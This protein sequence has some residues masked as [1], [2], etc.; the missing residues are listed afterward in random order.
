VSNSAWCIDCS[1]STVV[2]FN[3]ALDSARD[4]QPEAGEAGILG[5]L[6]FFTVH[7]PAAQLPGGA[8]SLATLHPRNSCDTLS[9]S[10]GARFYYQALAVSAKP[11]N[12]KF[13]VLGMVH[14][15]WVGWTGGAC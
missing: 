7:E 12:F 10:S 9:P 6:N 1:C 2:L 11:G 3:E 13:C 14:Q 15:D 4:A 5:G 8:P